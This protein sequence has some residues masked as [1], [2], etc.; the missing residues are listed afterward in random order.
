[1]VEIKV[2]GNKCII[3]LPY[4]VIYLC[5]YLIIKYLFSIIYFKIEDIKDVLYALTWEKSAKYDTKVVKKNI[6]YLFTKPLMFYIK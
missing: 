4:S 1:M 5:G 6:Y 2:L 3:P